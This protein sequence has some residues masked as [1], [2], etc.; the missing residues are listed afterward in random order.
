MA[1]V[2]TPPK[3][4]RLLVRIAPSIGSGYADKRRAKFAAWKGPKAKAA[5]SAG[6]PFFL[7]SELGLSGTLGRHHVAEQVPGLALEALQLDRL[8]RIEV[9]GAGADRDAGQ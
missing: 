7:H 9:G 8:D 1:A 2:D 6:R 5:G 3:K 4:P